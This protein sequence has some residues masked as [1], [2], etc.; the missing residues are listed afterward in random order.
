M[1][2][3][4]KSALA[5]LAAVALGGL[6][7]AVA[8]VGPAQA[9]KSDC[10]AGRVC[11]W[12]SIN[13]AGSR[14]EFTIGQMLAASNDCIVLGSAPNNKASSVFFN[15]SFAGSTNEI[16]FWDGNRSGAARSIVTNGYSDANMLTAPGMTD[17][18]NVASTICAVSR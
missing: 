1:H 9:A 2:D 18:S 11:I 14:W 3:K 17:F 13:Y 16:K 6:G 5:A 4:I 10:T 15:G 7:G 8:V 12:D